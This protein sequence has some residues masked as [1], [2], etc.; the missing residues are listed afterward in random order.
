MA[1][2]EGGVIGRM[3]KIG[4]FVSRDE[5]WLDGILRGQFEIV[6]ADDTSL[7]LE[8]LEESYDYT[9]FVVVDLELAEEN[10]YAFLKTIHDEIK[11]SFIPVLATVDITPTKEDAKALKYGIV[12]FIRRC[13]APIV[14]E[15]TISNAIR[16]KDSKTYVEL[17]QMLKQL[18]SLI[19]LKDSE[20]R[21][22]FST[23]YWHHLEQNE[24][25]W[26]IRG[27]TDLEIRKDRENA[28]LAMQADK[29]IIE[30]G[31]GTRYTI[32]IEVDDRLEYYDATKQPVFNAKGEVNGIIALLNDVTE[33]ELLKKKLELL[34]ITDGMTGLLNRTEIQQRIAKGLANG[35][36][37]SLTLIMLDIDNFKHINDTYGHQQG[38][39]VIKS[40][41]DTLKTEC[42]NGSGHYSAGRW[43]GEEFMLVLLG[44]G[45]ATA[46]NMAEEIRAL[47]ENTEFEGVPHQTVSLGVT[48]AK[49][50]DTVDTLCSRVDHAMYEAKHAGKNTVC[51]L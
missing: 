31:E 38:D 5:N 7:A 46:T 22:V 36:N 26:T 44:T 16:I 4:L 40:L 50:D 11:Y 12:D 47:F 34:S 20:G 41:A 35:S 42:E 18:P 37:P 10:D 43:G 6:H 30:T 51:V 25:N 15:N 1:S 45:L 8:I 2:P 14:T 23:H 49:A 9:S 13:A 21:Y 32:K 33:Q 27:K 17:E 28:I 24:P 19:Y 29:R 39:T 48:E 3:R